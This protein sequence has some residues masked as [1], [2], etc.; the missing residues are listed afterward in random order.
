MLKNS[1]VFAISSV[2][3]VISLVSPALA[4][5]ADFIGTWVNTNSSTS[6]VT[7]LVITSAGN[8]LNI[9]TFGKC[10]PTDCKWG[11][12][13]LTTYSSNVQ[14]PNTRYGTA[15]YNPGFSQTL[16]TLDIKG[17]N[18]LSLQ[19]FTQFT[20]NSKRQNYSSIENFKR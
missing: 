10:H 20:D 4:V 15:I 5:P 13:S 2:S 16:L 8:K 6:G 17:K 14:D 3:L 11:T 1:F 7:R 12:T 18:A 19:N 9:E